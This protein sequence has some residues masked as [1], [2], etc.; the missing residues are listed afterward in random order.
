M[1]AISTQITILLSIFWMFCC[2]LLYGQDTIYL[3]NPSFEDVPRKG[4]PGAPPIF[5]W[6]DCAAVEF[7]TESPPD[8]HPVYNNAWGVTMQPQNGDTYLGLVVRAAHSWE[9]V[10]QKLNVPLK[11]DSCYTLS[12]M[13]AVSDTYL[14][15]TRYSQQYGNNKLESFAQPVMLVIWGGQHECDKQEILA[16][17]SDV[18]Y[19]EWRPYTF[20]LSPLRNYNY[21]TLEAYYSK[22][23]LQHYNGHIM[24]DNLSPIIKID[25]K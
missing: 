2:Q 19:V 17:S 24:V 3:K 12:V 13:L 1:E 25:C 22:S 21:I 11:A 9:S 20:V 15:A 5:M 16:E 7:P 23:S 14:S 10:G 8:I 18:K 6:K 4:T